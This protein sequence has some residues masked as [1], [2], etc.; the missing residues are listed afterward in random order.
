MRALLALS[1]LALTACREGPEGPGLHVDA[2]GDGVVASEDCNDHDATVYPG[3]PGLCD[4]IDN[5]CDGVVDNDPV[6]GRTFY[7]DADGD[8]YGDPD[9]VVIACDPPEG[10]VYNADD[11]D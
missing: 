3:A 9:D 11:C 5:D 10:Y 7:A 8:G 4:G 1:L 2:D 6:N